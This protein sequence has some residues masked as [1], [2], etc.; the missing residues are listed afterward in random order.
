MLPLNMGNCAYGRTL[1]LAAFFS[2]L[3]YIPIVVICGGLKGWL[4]TMLLTNFVIMSYYG[5]Y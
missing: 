4:M 3:S 5:A 2:L 1:V